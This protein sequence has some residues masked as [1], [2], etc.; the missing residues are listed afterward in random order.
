MRTSF[1]T[2]QTLPI[3]KR[4]E[5]L[6]CMQ[7]MFEENED[8]IV[9]ALKE[10]LN[11]PKFEGVIYDNL[12]A[13]GEIKEMIHNMKAW[14]APEEQGFNLLTFPSSQWL[15]KEPY[16]VVLVIGECQWSVA[17]SRDNAR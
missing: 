16:G 1:N 10:D 11:R 15:Q 2:G 6:K 7:R 17:G 13:I 8:A 14:T 3:A 9:A 5:Q 4:M 12:V